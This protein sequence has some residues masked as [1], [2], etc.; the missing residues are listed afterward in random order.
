VRHSDTLAH[1]DVFA[2]ALAWSSRRTIAA[3]S[4]SFVPG[5]ALAGGDAES[6]EPPPLTGGCTQADMTMIAA[7]QMDLSISFPR[8]VCSRLIAIGSVL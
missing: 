4:A 7:I 5:R 6:P 1:P 8:E 2:I 3:Q